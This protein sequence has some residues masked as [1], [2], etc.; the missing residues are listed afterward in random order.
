MPEPILFVVDAD[1]AVLQSLAAVLERRFGADYR[2]LADASPASALARIEQA[3]ERGEKVALAVAS[4]TSA[5]DWSV[6]V[7]ACGRAVA[8]CTASLRRRGVPARRCRGGPPPVARVGTHRPL[9]S[10]DLPRPGAQRSDERRDCRDARRTHRTRGWALRSR[11]R[12]GGT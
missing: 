9:A 7:R 3:C 6:R 1:P 5:P 4:E 10:R 8:S 2:I 12:R 11:H